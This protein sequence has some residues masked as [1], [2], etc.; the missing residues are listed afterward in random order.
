[1]T[2]K[3]EFI[4]NGVK[5]I[6][7]CHR[8]NLLSASMEDLQLT[9]YLIVKDWMFSTLNQK[10]ARISATSVQNYTGCSSQCI[11]SGKERHPIGKEVKI[12]IQINQMDGLYSPS[13]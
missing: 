11:E 9:S 8:F 1:M 3:I 12:K 2:Q 13:M 6:T 10:Q 7:V 4:N 5:I